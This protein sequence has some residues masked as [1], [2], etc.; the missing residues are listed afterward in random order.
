MPLIPP[1]V[2]AALGGRLKG[3]SETRT[4]FACA[5][6][7]SS[8]LY[9]VSCTGKAASDK[10][11]PHCVQGTSSHTTTHESR[12]KERLKLSASTNRCSASVLCSAPSHSWHSPMMQQL[13][14]SRILSVYSM[15]VGGSAIHRPRMQR[16]H[17][18]LQLSASCAVIVNCQ[19]CRVS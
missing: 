16:H 9:T 5:L 2:L 4:S 8:L 17:R 10:V 18:A 15:L 13:G 19:G 11:P 7:C 12:K 14:M 1:G 3:N 6:I